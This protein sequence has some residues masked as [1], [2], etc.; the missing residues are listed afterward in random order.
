ML[1]VEKKIKIIY[2]L[3]FNHPL[4]NTDT[5]TRTLISAAD[6]KYVKVCFYILWILEFQNKSLALYT[7]YTTGILSLEFA[8]SIFMKYCL[9]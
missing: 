8:E 9:Y 7:T 4:S 6:F 1:W 2:E 3:S 5:R